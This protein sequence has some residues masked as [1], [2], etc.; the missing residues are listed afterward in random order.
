MELRR[1]NELAANWLAAGVQLDEFTQ[2]PLIKV[3]NLLLPRNLPS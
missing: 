3:V 2:N 1:K